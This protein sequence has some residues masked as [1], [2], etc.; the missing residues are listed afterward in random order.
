METT[1]TPAVTP[2]AVGIRFGL[3]LGLGWILVDFVLRQVG[4]SFL[5]YGMVT[6][7]ASILVSAGAI[8][9]AHRAFKQGNNGLMTYL[10]GLGIALLM[11]L[12]WGFFSAVFNYVYV[13]YVDPEF[14]DKLRDGM[15]EFMERHHA[16]ENQIEESAA[17]FDEMK[18]GF[19]HTLLSALRSGLIMGVL[20]GAIVSIFTKRKHPEFE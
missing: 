1:I 12:L 14:V 4:L 6:A 10:T 16:P 7:T 2:V 11:M 13:H 17:R 5:S 20:L 18:G 15:V 9:A 8:V 19:A 3:L